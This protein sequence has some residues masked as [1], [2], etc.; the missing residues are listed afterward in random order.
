[1]LCRFINGI[2]LFAEEQKSCQRQNS[3]AIMLI[4]DRH[5]SGVMKYG[6]EEEGGRQIKFDSTEMKRLKDSYLEMLLFLFHRR[7]KTKHLSAL[8]LFSFDKFFGHH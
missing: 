2:T 4:L 6:A 3:F 7:P 5:R 1:M 8:E